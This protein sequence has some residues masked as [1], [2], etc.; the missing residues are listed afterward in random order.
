MMNLRPVHL[1]DTN[2]K[3]RPLQDSDYDEL[4]KAASDPLIW[5]QHPTSD[6]YKPEV[7]HKYFEGAIKSKSAFK[8]IEG[9]SEKIIG[10]TRYYDYIQSESRIA[11]GFTFLAKEYWGGSYNKS[12]K[13]LLLDYA[14]RFV[15]KVYFHIATTNIRSQKAIEN[16]G[17]IKVGEVDFDYYG[18]KLLHYEYVIMKVNTVELS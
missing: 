2:V 4:Y 14:F 9:S 3:L 6:R 11:I 8:I 18:G 17:A 16:I 5:K 10:S 7:F 13:K 1:E 15:D 12:V